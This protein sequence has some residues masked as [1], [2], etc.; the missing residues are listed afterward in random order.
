[1]MVGD[2]CQMALQPIYEEV[3]QKVSYGLLQAISIGIGDVV[4]DML[5]KTLDNV[6]CY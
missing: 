3:D 6:S 4:S 5:Q 2:C 1:M